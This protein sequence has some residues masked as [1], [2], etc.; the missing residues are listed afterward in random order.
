MPVTEGVVGGEEVEDVVEGE[1]GPGDELEVGVDCGALD[2]VPSACATGHA[3]LAVD[4]DHLPLTGGDEVGR[5]AQRAGGVMQGEPYGL[6]HDALSP[7]TDVP[8]AVVEFAGDALFMGV[9][10]CLPS[11]KA[12]HTGECGA[13]RPW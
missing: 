1:G 6:A 7:G 13:P 8:A 9:T 5:P 3:A 2:D 12:R 10:D 4:Q 11:L